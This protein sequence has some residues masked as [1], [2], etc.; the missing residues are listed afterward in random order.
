MEQDGQTSLPSANTDQHAD[1]LQCQC[2]VPLCLICTSSKN[3]QLQNNVMSS[4]T[5][6]LEA[7]G[8]KL[9]FFQTRPERGLRNPYLLH[10]GYT[11]R[12]I[13]FCPVYRQGNGKPSVYDII[14]TADNRSG[15][16]QAEQVYHVSFFRHYSI[17]ALAGEK[18]GNSQ[19]LLCYSLLCAILTDVSMPLSSS[20]NMGS[21]QQGQFPLT[22]AISCVRP[23]LIV[24]LQTCHKSSQQVGGV[25]IMALPSVLTAPISFR[26]LIYIKLLTLDHVQV[27]NQGA[28]YAVHSCAVVSLV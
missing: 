1:I 11:K 6:F 4:L 9:R 27:H 19:G 8:S 20:E 10:C 13:T 24:I 26:L 14:N 21:K 5:R 28:S 22:G 23:Q 2:C 25:V 15:I 17:A 7:E 16:I 3:R 18:D 12:I